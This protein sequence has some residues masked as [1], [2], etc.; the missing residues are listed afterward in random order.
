MSNF[1]NLRPPIKVFPV[2]ISLISGYNKASLRK[3]EK[4]FQE[5][6][7]KNMKEN[8]NRMK[9]KWKKRG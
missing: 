5:L 9:I 3:P 7:W 6:F 8:Q 4:A 1:T 2:E